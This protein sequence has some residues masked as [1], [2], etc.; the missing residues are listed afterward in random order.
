MR[1]TRAGAR[2]P[3]PIFSFS[4]FDLVV[5]TRKL[6][7][8]YQGPC[9]RARKRVGE[10]Q[11]DIGF[12]ASGSIDTAELAA[13]AS[14]EVLDCHTWY[15]QSQAGADVG[16]SG[17]AYP[18]VYNGSAYAGGMQCSD[19]RDAAFLSSTF[20]DPG[21]QFT[22][23]MR[24]VVDNTTPAEAMF[25]YGEDANNRYISCTYN[26]AVASKQAFRIR[27]GGSVGLNYIERSGGISNGEHVIAQAVD[28]DAATTAG[29]NRVW[30]DNTAF[31]VLDT[32]GSLPYSTFP[33]GRWSIGCA[34]DN[35]EA[36]N[37]RFT[38]F[39]VYRGLLT[40]AQISAVNQRLAE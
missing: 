22:V 8:G 9:M 17:A 32:G 4:G 1:S 36:S 18:E 30:V 26:L 11:Q 6:V 21:K 15:N 12:T 39:L 38:D 13:F 25:E 16:A 7:Y 37:H 33:D 40:D 10:Q 31:G 34:S 28:L 29:M 2:I 5:S 19:P 23:F 24:V 14:G 35:A 20:T 27:S 3:H